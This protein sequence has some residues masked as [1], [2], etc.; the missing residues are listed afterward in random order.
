[1]S[2]VYLIV[3]VLYKMKAVINFLR[4]GAPPP[5]PPWMGNA[6]GPA[7]L[8]W[9]RVPNVLTSQYTKLETNQEII[10]LNICIFEV[11]D[12]ILSFFVSPNKYNI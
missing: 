8:Q 12:I 4:W 11:T 2:G 3:L 6:P 10:L 5:M 7:F 1:M 9:H